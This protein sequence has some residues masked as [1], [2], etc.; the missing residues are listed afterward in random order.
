[1]SISAKKLI[2][3]KWYK[4]NTFYNVGYYLFCFGEIKN[5]MIYAMSELYIHVSFG[6]G[7]IKYLNTDNLFATNTNNKYEK[8]NMKDVIIYLPDNHID[9]I[10]YLRKE[11]IKNLLLIQ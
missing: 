8:V 9:K 1:M 2:P 3:G 5:D 10:N 6:V 7:N 11:R 4:E